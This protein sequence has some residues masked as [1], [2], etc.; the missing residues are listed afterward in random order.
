MV[1][2]QAAAR[3]GVA[4]VLIGTAE[5]YG[6]SV[7]IPYHED[8]RCA[9]VSVYGQSK[10][11]ATRE[12]LAAWPETVSV[13]RPA[14]IYGANQP[15]FMLVASCVSAALTGGEVRL[16]GGQQ[17]RDHVYVEDAAQAVV[18]AVRRHR[19][20]RGQIVNVGSGQEQSI[21]SIAEKVIAIAGRGRVVLDPPSDR[22]GDVHRMSMSTERAERLLGW[23]AQTSLD[24]GLTKTLHALQSPGQTEL[25]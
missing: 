5:E 3:F 15:G 25:T 8:A 10:L 14:V 6:P 2:A 7:P 16:R 1:V 21:V 13:L 18:Q 19:D 20:V 22:P 4:M 9:P 23:R 12:A 17:T 11:V 24:L